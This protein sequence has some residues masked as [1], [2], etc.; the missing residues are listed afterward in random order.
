MSRI[1]PVR[2]KQ[3]GF[4]IADIPRPF[5]ADRQSAPFPPNSEAARCLTTGSARRN[6]IR[7][8][9][10]SRTPFPCGERFFRT[11]FRSID[12][13]SKGIHILRARVR[14]PGKELVTFTEK[15]F[16]SRDTWLVTAVERTFQKTLVRRNETIRS[17][18]RAG[19]ATT[20]KTSRGSNNALPTIRFSVSIN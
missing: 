5:V 8:M 13:D 15:V 3:P 14:R 10:T 19:Y 20:D 12:V 9:K 17:F 4:Q 7:P 16:L 6:P 2:L 18:C 11:N 1:K